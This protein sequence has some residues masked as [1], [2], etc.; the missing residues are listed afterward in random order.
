MIISGIGHYQQ[1]VMPEAQT[2]FETIVQSY[3]QIR[4][5]YIVAEVERNGEFYSLKLEP[6]GEPTAPSV[7]VSVHKDEVQA[8]ITRN[9]LTDSVIQ[10]LA[11]VIE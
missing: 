8:S 5:G 3:V 6:L 2:K 7:R 10:S 9:G 11:R 1:N 4:F